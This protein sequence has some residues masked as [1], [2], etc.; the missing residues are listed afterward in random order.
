[1]SWLCFVCDEIVYDHVYPWG[2]VYCCASCHAELT[3]VRWE[4]E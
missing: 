1:M 3:D 2:D 4:E